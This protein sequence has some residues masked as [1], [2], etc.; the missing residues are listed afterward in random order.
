MKKC[1]VVTPV[2]TKNPLP[3]SGNATFVEMLIGYV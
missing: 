3:Q 2:T 1:S